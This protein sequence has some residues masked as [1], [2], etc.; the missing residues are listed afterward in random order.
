MKSIIYEPVVDSITAPEVIGCY[1][2]QGVRRLSKIKE[3]NIVYSDGTIQKV[4]F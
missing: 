3:L 4:I 1:S 2:M